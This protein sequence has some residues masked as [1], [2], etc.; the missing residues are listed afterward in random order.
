MEISVRLRILERITTRFPKL[1][2][3]MTGRGLLAHPELAMEYKQD[4]HLSDDERMENYHQL[5]RFG[6][7][8]LPERLKG[9]D[10]Q[11]V[12]K[13]KDFC[14][15][16]SILKWIKKS[17]SH[18]KAITILQSTRMQL[19]LEDISIRWLYYLR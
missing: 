13:M 3:V 8:S 1:A 18:K 16:I 10:A 7:R 19:F 15:S 14:G 11:V 4:V 12:S 6:L 5:H 2:G 17:Q 9:G